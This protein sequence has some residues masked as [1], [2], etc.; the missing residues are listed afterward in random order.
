M[1][2]PGTDA[3]LALI[4][5]AAHEA[6]ALARDIRRRGLEVDY[7]PEDRS[8]VTNADLAADR[9]LTERLRTARPDY[10]WLS[11]ETAD[12]RDRLDRRR[13]FVVDPI[14]GTRAF[15]NGR[16]WWSV[17]IAVVEDGL[18]TSAVVFA[19]ETDE[20]YAAAAGEGATRNGEAIRPSRALDLADCRMAGDSMVFSHWS[21]PTPWPAMRVE[22]RSS[23]AY[24]MCLVAAGD[25]DAAVAPLRKSDW[26][27]AAGDL[28]A[29]EAGCFVGD[30]TG[31][32]FRYNRARPSQASLICA[33]PALAPLILDRVRHIGASN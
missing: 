26:D 1:T 18:P 23:T 10:G 3:D 32:G 13:I 15:L 12:D 20:T 7:K 27:V 17:A 2:H 31:A 30:H 29:R 8:P 6:G 24:R 16:P 9:L 14:D 11:E 28:I 22:P 19:P 33:T 5:D 25:F 21:W 4:L